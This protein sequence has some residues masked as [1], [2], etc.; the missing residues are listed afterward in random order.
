MVNRIGAQSA[1][2]QPRRA[3]SAVPTPEFTIVDDG[4]PDLSQ[5]PRRVS[6]NSGGVN[7]RDP[8]RQTRG[9][10]PRLASGRR[11]GTRNTADD[12]HPE[13][14]KE[15]YQVDIRPLEH[16]SYST[17]YRIWMKNGTMRMMS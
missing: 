11:E 16:G 2:G 14:V 8:L 17:V 6:Y 9:S 10:Q 13:D 5:A 7:H 12:I 4:G 3:T 1:Q 15:V